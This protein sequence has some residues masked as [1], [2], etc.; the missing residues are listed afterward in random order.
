MKRCCDCLK[1]LPLSAFYRQKG[2]SFKRCK[3]CHT[4]FGA[5]RRAR[6]RTEGRCL[7]GRKRLLGRKMCGHCAQR[8][9]DR[10]H[11]RVKNDAGYVRK[12]RAVSVQRS[13]AL[14]LAALDAY[15]GCSCA[16]CGETHVEFL[17]IDHVNKPAKDTP[18]SGKS[19]Y[20]WLKTNGYPTGFRVLCL[21]CN[22]AFGHYGYCPH[23]R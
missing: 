10:Y 14:K 8:F 3:Q 20:Q 16:C 2:R 1:K 5:L 22:F 21:N 17:T 23:S 15:G 13:R 6:Y 11:R 4:K 18:R 12:L 19:F 9:N 7:C